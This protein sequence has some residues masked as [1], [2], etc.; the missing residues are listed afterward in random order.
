MPELYGNAVPRERAVATVV[1]A[2]ASPINF[3]DTSNGYGNGTSEE[4][5]GEGIRLYGGLPDEYVVATKVDPDP[6]TGEFS[7]E[8]VRISLAESMGRLGI[9]HLRLLHL[10]DPERIGFAEAMSSG[11]A[12][13]GLVHLR[14]SGVV[15]YIGVAGGPID[16]LVRFVETDLF[17]VVLTHNRYTLIDRSAD[18]LLDLAREKGIGVLNAAPYGGGILAKG[19][20]NRSRYAYGLGKSSLA[21]AAAAMWEACTRHDVP[22]AAAA[23]QFSVREPRIDSTVVGMS[24][25]QRI[26]ETL[27]LLDVPIPDELWEELARVAPRRDMWLG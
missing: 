17:D 16:L 22:L 18:R 4:R 2:L 11:G 8:R 24:A 3:L 25:P 27:S 21:D 19:P 10:H 12:V 9:E 6:V 13:E 15:D 26:N 1:T 5:V 7:G 23:L 14:E 20:H